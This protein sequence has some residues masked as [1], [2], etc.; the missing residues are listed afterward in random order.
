VLLQGE[1]NERNF[2]DWSIGFR[3]LGEQNALKTS[4]FND[5]LNTPLTGA[6][7]AKDPSRSM[8]LLLLFQ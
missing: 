4:G 1:T 5:F 2:G 6:E 7:F 8:K 3:D